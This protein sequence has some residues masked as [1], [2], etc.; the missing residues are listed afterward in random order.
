MK[1]NYFT[2][3]LLLSLFYTPVAY[4]ENTGLGFDID[5]GENGG[6]TEKPTSDNSQTCTNSSTIMPGINDLQKSWGYMYV[7]KKLKISAKDHRLNLKDEGPQEICLVGLAANDHE[8]N[9]DFATNPRPSD[10]AYN[11]DGIHLGVKNRSRQQGSWE[12]SAKL[13]LDDQMSSQGVQ[14]VS[15]ETNIRDKYEGN[16]QPIQDGELIAFDKRALSSR[17]E[18]APLILNSDA[19]MIFQGKEDIV[20]NGTYDCRFR[21]MQIHI[22]DTRRLQ[23]GNH[24]V[25]L[26]WNLSS[27]PSA[28]T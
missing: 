13:Q 17:W 18:G 4:A 3:V 8:E 1:R 25:Q 28:R 2:W 22:P 16:M 26:Q 21:K 9:P 19:T 12:L 11:T 6:Q 10:S 15:R 14:L 27:V 20:H 7:P 5:V 24:V 23:D